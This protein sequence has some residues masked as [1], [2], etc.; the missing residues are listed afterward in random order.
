MV[1]VVWQELRPCTL[2]GKPFLFAQFFD[3][4]GYARVTSQDVT[5][6]VTLIFSRFGRSIKPASSHN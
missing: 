6:G 5:Q 2:G 1:D 4:R 3:C